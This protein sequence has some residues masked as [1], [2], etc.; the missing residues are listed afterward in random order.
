MRQKSTFWL[1]W[2]CIYVIVSLSLSFPF[3][4]PFFPF[5]VG[6]HTEFS[7]EKMTLTQQISA[8]LFW[9]QSTKHLLNISSITSS[10]DFTT[11]TSGSKIHVGVFSRLCSTKALGIFQQRK[12]EAGENVFRYPLLPLKGTDIFTDTVLFF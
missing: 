11:M 4:L 5:Y 6:K 3:C 7:L 9:N 1:Y 2:A 10:T 8:T 12:T